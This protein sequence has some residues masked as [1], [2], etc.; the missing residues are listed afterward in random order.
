MSKLDMATRQEESQEQALE[1][2]IHSFPQPGVPQKYKA[3][4][5]NINAEDPWGPMLGPTLDAS[6]S[7]SLYAPP[8]LGVL[9]T[10]FLPLLPG[11]SPSSKS[12]DLMETFHLDSLSA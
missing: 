12:R 4:S 3:N 7:V 5:Y 11:D 1:S 8:S 2:E 10:F 9:H 6:V